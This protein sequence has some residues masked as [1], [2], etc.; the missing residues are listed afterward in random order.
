MVKL[1]ISIKEYP[2]EKNYA[3]NGD[4]TLLLVYWLWGR[5]NEARQ[6]LGCIIMSFCWPMT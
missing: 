3:T 6:F 2:V 1:G 5:L 4:F